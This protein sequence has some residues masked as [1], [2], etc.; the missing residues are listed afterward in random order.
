MA[1]A[2]AGTI[3]GHGQRLGGAIAM[4]S[5]PD[6]DRLVQTT[7]GF[8][9]GPVTAGYNGRRRRWEVTLRHGDQRCHVTMLTDGVDRLLRRLGL[10]E[11]DIQR[12]IVIRPRRHSRKDG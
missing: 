8:E 11:A 2:M 9:V 7:F 4:E 12:A 5:L 3:R 10:D 6:T 1:P